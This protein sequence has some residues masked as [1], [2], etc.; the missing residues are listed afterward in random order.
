VEMTLDDG[1]VDPNDVVASETVGDSEGDSLND[2]GSLDAEMVGANGT[3]DG[4][5][6]LA[7][8]G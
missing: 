4:T 7:S 8:I 5:L 2:C 1:I 3:D 6:L